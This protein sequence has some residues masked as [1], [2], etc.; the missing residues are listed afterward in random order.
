[1]DNIRSYKI[2]CPNCVGRLMLCQSV[3]VK[4]S[5]IFTVLVFSFFV[6]YIGILLVGDL[7]S[8]CNN[9]Y[10]LGKFFK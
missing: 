7:V 9:T 10:L 4:F 2:V 5:F 8:F 6:K 3:I 1:M